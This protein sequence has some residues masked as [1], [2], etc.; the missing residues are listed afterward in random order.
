MP[1]TVDK[2]AK[3]KFLFN[4]AI[5]LFAERG[6]DYTTMDDIAFS[7]GI[8]KSTIYEYYR[9]KEEF[10]EDAYKIYSKPDLTVI[11]IL[12][13]RKLTPLEKLKQLTIHTLIEL[14][15]EKEISQIIL[16]L[17]TEGNA[18]PL[19]SKIN[20]KS[21]YRDYRRIVRYL[22]KAAIKKGEVRKDI[23]KN[24]DSILLGMLEGISLQM[25]AEPTLFSPKD[26]GEDIINAIVIGIKA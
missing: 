4:T 3:R 15:K 25:I 8:G 16:N 5:K 7:A 13:S 24:M 22:L 11:K 14:Q 17:W 19:H 2:K 18:T 20:L 21:V 26:I 1:R 12:A 23:P 10:I 6:Y 9:S